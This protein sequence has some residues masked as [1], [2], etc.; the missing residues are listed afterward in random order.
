MKTQKEY[1]KDFKDTHPISE[2]PGDLNGLWKWARVQDCIDLRY[3]YDSRKAAEMDRA[4]CAKAACGAYLRENEVISCSRC[5][6]ETTT[7]W[8]EKTGQCLS[9]CDAETANLR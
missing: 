6:G 1:I 9:C 3:G 8:I 5:G 7:E 4:E 2:W